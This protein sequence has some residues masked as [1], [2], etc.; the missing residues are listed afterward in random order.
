MLD[1]DF[2]GGSSVT[3]TLKDSD[4][5]PIAEVRDAL[6]ETELADKNLLIVERGDTNT[7]YHDRYQRTIGRQSQADRRAEH[8]ATN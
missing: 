1:I 8:S 3:F 4:K 2:T 7:R 5:M 6:D